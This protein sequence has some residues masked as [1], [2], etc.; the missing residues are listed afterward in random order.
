[1][2]HLEAVRVAQDAAY[3][4]S[5]SDADWHQ[6]ALDPTWQELV[7]EQSE[8]VASVLAVHGHKLPFAYRGNENATPEAA[9][10]PAKVVGTDIARIQGLGIVTN[11]G[12]YTEN[13]RM[14][15]MLFMRTLRSR[16]PHAKIT[17]VDISKAQKLPGVKA[18]LHRGNLPAEY[19]DVFLGAANPTRFLFNEEVFEVGS[20]IAVVAAESEHV[21]DEAL[22][23]I[24]VQYQV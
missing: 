15:G 4:A 17:S 16:Y 14:A 3:A 22:R 10:A 8:M 12:Q 20:P 11:L 19:A 6:L 21:A 24:D 13:M 9:V 7:S 23:Q 18:V 1:M 2:A 5:L